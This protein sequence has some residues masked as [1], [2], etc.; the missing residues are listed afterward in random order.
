M[1]KSRRVIGVDE[2]GKGDF[3]GPLV[4]AAFFAPDSDCDRLHEYGVRD[5]KKL[6]DNRVLSIDEYLRNIYP[7]QVIVV[8]PP[9]YNKQ[10]QQ[11]K[12]LNKLLAKCH[13]DAIAG[14]L[15]Q[16]Q[17]DLV[18]V[19]QFGK[20]ELIED[21]LDVNGVSVKV[22][23]QFRGEEILQVAAASIMARA[24]FIR[25]M[26]NLS[27]KYKMTLPKGASAQVDQAGREFVSCY[28]VDELLQ[29]SKTH[30][31]NYHRVTNPTLFA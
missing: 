16:N 17:A 21:A 27:K 6:S 22:H 29:V 2:S 11:I 10:Y 15:K 30:F 19:D 13:A 24:A 18:V 26:D 7:H 1:V 14:V 25:E 8:S 12:N 28:G 23:Q 3:F 4:I 20:P 9:D 5:G 31:K